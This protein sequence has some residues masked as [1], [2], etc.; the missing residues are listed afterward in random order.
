MSKFISVVKF[1]VKIE[2]ERQFIESMQKFKLPDGLVYRKLIKT[3]DYSYCSIICTFYI[4]EFK[5]FKFH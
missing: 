1:K 2:E 3:G 5:N 4:F